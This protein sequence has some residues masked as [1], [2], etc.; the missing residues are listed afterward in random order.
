[1]RLLEKLFISLSF[2][3][4]KVCLKYWY[5]QLRTK[6]KF[7]AFLADVPR[8]SLFIEKLS[9]HLTCIALTVFSTTLNSYISSWLHLYFPFYS[10]VL[11]QYF[12]DNYWYSIIF[13]TFN[14]FLPIFPRVV[15]FYTHF[16]NL[17]KKIV[18]CIL[19]KFYNFYLFCLIFPNMSDC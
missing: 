12:P 14:H 17:K 10:H 15:P 11:A 16:D 2:G 4:C 9:T 8:F 6:K 18:F 13:V 1:M 3:F 7:G 5:F 19:T